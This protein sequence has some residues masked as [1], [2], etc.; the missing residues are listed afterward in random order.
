MDSFPYCVDTIVCMCV[1]VISIV[2][3]SGRVG[4]P[5]NRDVRVSVSDASQTTSG[6]VIRGTATSDSDSFAYKVSHLT[7]AIDSV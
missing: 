4:S 1:C 7:M 6:V 2:C 5:I 3:R